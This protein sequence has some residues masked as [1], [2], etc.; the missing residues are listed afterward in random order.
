MTNG[1][2][3]C[4]D[5]LYTVT[6]D[7]IS[8]EY[9]PQS[10]APVHCWQCEYY[11]PAKN[12]GVK[13]C[14]RLKDDKGKEAAYN[15]APG[16]FCS[17]GKVAESE[18][19]RLDDLREWLYNLSEANTYKRIRGERECF[20]RPEDFLEVLKSVKTISGISTRKTCMTVVKY[21]VRECQNCRFQF[22][23]DTSRWKR[24]PVCM[25]EIEKGD[26]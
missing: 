25:A 1:Q 21:G 16:D 3:Q 10:K 20:I 26:V 5:T 8:G 24:C 17:K 22:K 23:E 6:P 12:S 18:L 13:M 19:V 9:S 7:S 4:G 2:F 11:R 14:H 15:F